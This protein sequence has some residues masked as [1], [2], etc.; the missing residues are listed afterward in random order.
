MSPSDTADIIAPLVRHGMSFEQFSA[1]LKARSALLSNGQ[2]DASQKKSV[3]QAVMNEEEDWLD[4]KIARDFLEAWLGLKDET[5][6][7]SYITRRS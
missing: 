2:L 6:L 7:K 3:A 5:A 1:Y 4:W